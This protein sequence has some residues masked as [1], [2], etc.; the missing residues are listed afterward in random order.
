M[1]RY[2]RTFPGSL[3]SWRTLAPFAVLS[4]LLMLFAVGGII[5]IAYEADRSDASR[6]REA[7][8]RTFSALQLRLDSAVEM[9]AAA[10]PIASALSGPGATP[11]SAHG[12]LNFTSRDALGYYGTL[13]LNHDGT[14]FAGTR[15]GLPWEGPKLARAARI[16][17]PIAARLPDTSAGTVHTLVRDESGKALAIAV[18]NVMLRSPL[19]SAN[20]AAE[21]RRLAMMAPVGIQL[22]PKMLPQLGVEDFRIVAVGRNDNAVTI[23]VEHGPPIVF[24]WQPRRPGRAAVG[25]WAPAI[26]GLL[27][28]AL[29]ML[30]LAGR[31]NL[32]AIHA[33]KRLALLDSLTGLANRLAFSDELNGRLTDGGKLALGMIDL[34]GFKA[35]NDGHGHIVGDELLKA[36][37]AALAGS[38][39]P[40][41]F[42][43]RLGGDEFA[44][45]SSSREAANGLS[46][47]LNKRIS[48]PLDAGGLRLKIGATIGVAVATPGID[49]SAL[50]AS[51]DARLYESKRAARSLGHNG[52]P[53]LRTDATR[54]RA[55]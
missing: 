25:R 19:G 52:S 15:F 46:G 38:A 36:V 12:Y 51:A 17:A 11:G 43:A 42:V 3:A 55:A 41:D 45:I 5:V 26:A 39:G 28:T 24:T 30:V 22:A 9:N 1:T 13:V 7:V 23:P 4:L 47:E 18:T 49:A 16:V 40:G 14:P 50:L 35:I 2:S 32:N 44:W 29:I 34:D 37:A 10:P 20:Q 27:V 21:P 8:T 54:S 33:L 53:A 48:A 6:A 31:A